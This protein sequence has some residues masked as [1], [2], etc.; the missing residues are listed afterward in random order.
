MGEVYFARDTRLERTVAVKVLRAHFAENTELRVRFER[1]ARA[2]SSLNHPNICSLYDV[3]HHE[4]SDFLVMEFLEGETLAAR[5]QRGP[6][7]IDE[8]LRVAMQVA[9]A[10]E[11]AHKQGV[12]HRDLKPGNIMLT[13]SGAKLMDFGL[14]K[15]VSAAGAGSG[16]GLS[17]AVTVSSPASPLTMAGTIVGTFQY[18]SPE[19][20]EGRE[21]DARSDIFAFGAMLFEMLTG[22]RAFEGKSQAGVAAAVLALEPPPVSSLQPMTPP[23]LERLVKTCLAKDAEERFQTIHDVKLQLQWI[24][25]GGSQAGV[26]APMASRRKKREYLAWA[27]A[28]VLA[29]LMLGLGWYLHVPGPQPVIRSAIMLPEGHRLPT[30][31]SSLALSPDGTAVV[32]VTTGGVK[33]TQLWLRKLNSTTAQPLAGTEGADMP[34]WSPDGRYIAFFADKKLKKIPAEGGAAVTLCD[35]DDPRGGSWGSKDI[36]VFAPGPFTPLYK[37]SA[38]G[39]NAVAVTKLDK[40]DSTHRVPR[41]LPD[42]RHVLF[43][44][45]GLERAPTNGIYSL[46]L[47]TGKV[48]L[49]K[50]EESEGIYVNPGYL[51]FVEDGN[52]MAQPFD[53][54]SQKVRGE[55]VPIVESVQ[56]N[57]Y[58]WSGAYSFS[59]N[60]LMVYAPSTNSGS[61]QLAWFDM[62]GHKLSTVGDPGNLGGVVLS[63]DEKAAAVSVQTQRET[64]IWIYDLLRGVGTRF[65]FEKGSSFDPVWS[66]D[67][68]KIVYRSDEKSIGNELYIK[69]VTGISTAALLLSGGGPKLPQSWSPDGK[70]LLYAFQDAK[71][72][73]WDLWVLPMQGEKK[74]FP[75]LAS[76]ANERAGWFSPDGKW[77]AYTSDESGKDQLYVTPFPSASA[78]WQVSS[79]GFACCTTWAEQGQTLLYSTGEQLYRTDL[80]LSDNGV[81]FGG[82]RSLVPMPDGE[83]G[84]LSKD[85]KRMLVA[86]YIHSQEQPTLTLVTNWQADLKK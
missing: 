19:Q 23:A 77:L 76:A 81:T 22:K 16:S 44:S 86:S 75:F 69:P 48:I 35:A 51:V 61:T 43:Y 65:T 28:G 58:R 57:P 67:G 6:M 66:P 49:V 45:G 39:G 30:T 24:A 7:P 68:K 9:D 80:K 17:A 34:F 59:D 64:S 5:L 3:G 2:V 71:T 79:N 73:S 37:V 29:V 21:V 18:M 38:T 12:I 20:V 11:Q 27:S 55:A 41:F 56:F 36:I 72:S 85:G 60:G 31:N 46:D 1:E 63:P 42:G 14:A 10:L 62:E 74:P 40:G 4:G 84:D 54:N 83:G 52:L 50:H 70:Y 8:V 78:K 47:D 33:G 82:T 25:E 15:S 26:A 32:F 13:K 53:A